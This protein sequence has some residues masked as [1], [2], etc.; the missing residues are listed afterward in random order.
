MELF[1]NFPSFE[2]VFAGLGA[3]GKPDRRS[4]EPSEDI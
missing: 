1:L 3:M 2:V 4:A